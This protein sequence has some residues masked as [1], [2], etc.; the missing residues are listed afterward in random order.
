MDTRLK[1]AEEHLADRQDTIEQQRRD[2]ARL[3]ES[4]QQQLADVDVESVDTYEDALRERERLEAQRSEAMTVLNRFLSEPATDDTETMRETWKRALM[5]WNNRPDEQGSTQ[6][7]FD[8][9][10]IGFLAEEKSRLS[11][12]SAQLDPELTAFEEASNNLIAKLQR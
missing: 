8:E 7:T 5:A 4:L 12:K 3:Q 6:S 10:R 1:Y 9:S 2:I 11:E